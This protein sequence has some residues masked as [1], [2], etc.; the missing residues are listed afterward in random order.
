MSRRTYRTEF[1]EFGDVPEVA[2]LLSMGMRDESWHNDSCPRIVSPSRS[3]IVWIEHA[4]PQL[5]EPADGPRF[6]VQ[7]IGSD[8]HSEHPFAYIGDDWQCARAAAVAVRELPAGLTDD[9]AARICSGADVL[10]LI[11]GWESAGRIGGHA[12]GV[13]ADWLLR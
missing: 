12:R 2:E 13:L 8:D 6:C 4:D 3:A 11:D 5:R 9:E 10:G 7:V 1:P